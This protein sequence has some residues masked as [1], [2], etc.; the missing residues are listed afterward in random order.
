MHGRFVSMRGRCHHIAL[1]SMA[2]RLDSSRTS[3]EAS[4]EHVGRRRMTTSR[5]DFVKFAGTTTAML[6]ATGAIITAPVAQPWAE[7]RLV[8][9]AEINPASTAEREFKFVNLERLKAK[10]ARPS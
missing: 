9:P 5:R 10:R 4:N 8:P 3:R 2:V 6:A 1:T 7:E